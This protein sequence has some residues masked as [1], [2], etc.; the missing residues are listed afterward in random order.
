MLKIKNRYTDEILWKSDNIKSLRNADL[1]GVSLS[2]ANLWSADLQGANLSRAHLCNAYLSGADLS[3]ANLREANLSEADLRWADLRGANLSEADLRFAT[4]LRFAN[5]SGTN[6]SGTNLS[7][8]NLSG[9]DFS[10]VDLS[11]VDLSEAKNLNANLSG[12][13]LSGVIFNDQSLKVKR[14]IMTKETIDKSAGVIIFDSAK[15]GV[16]LG[17]VNKIGDALLEIASKFAVHNATVAGLLET[18]E[19]REIVKGVI[20]G[21]IITVGKNELLPKGNKQLVAIGELQITAST[22]ILF[23]KYSKILENEIGT[24]IEIGSSLGEAAQAQD[25]LPT[26]ER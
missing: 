15:L 16:K 9:V 21:A 12:T 23:S 6:L 19:G 5:L 1:Q 22:F 2:Q 18:D 20:A 11:D 17:A 3:G 8:T 26:L 14:A 25:L 4:D 24:L 13:N 7:G 10:D